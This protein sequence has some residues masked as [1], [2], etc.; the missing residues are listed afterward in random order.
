MHFSNR[1]LI[2]LLPVVIPIVLYNVSPSLLFVGGAYLVLLFVVC[3]I[4]Y[5]TNPVVWKG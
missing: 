2:Y 5:V 4:D 1:L 3:A